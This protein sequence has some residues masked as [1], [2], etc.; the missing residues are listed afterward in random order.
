MAEEEKKAAGETKSVKGAWDV[1]YRWTF[2][3][4]LMDR[5]VAG[6]KEKKLWGTKCHRCGRVYVPPKDICGKCFEEID[7][8]WV[9]VKDRAELVTYTVGYTS[10]TGQ[11]YPEPQITGTVRFEGSDS[12]AL[13][14]IRGL[15]PEDIKVGMKLKVVWR[16]ETKGQL[17][18]IEHYAPAE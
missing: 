12:W 9:E 4:D 10:I 13:G 7:E 15:K 3:Q 8:N 11:P 14:P 17:S 2:R 16:E 1:K 6:L 5:Y 18:D